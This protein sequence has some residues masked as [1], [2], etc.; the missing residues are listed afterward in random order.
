MS[1]LTFQLEDHFRFLAEQGD[2][3][4]ARA[5]YRFLSGFFAFVGD[6]LHAC[7]NGLRSL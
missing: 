5:L 6:V 2:G 4:L 7:T 3:L 1:R